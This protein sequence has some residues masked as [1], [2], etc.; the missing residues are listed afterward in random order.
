[1]IFEIQSNRAMN[2]GEKLGKLIF[3]ESELEKKIYGIK[4]H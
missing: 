2:H 3:L 1:M 4:N